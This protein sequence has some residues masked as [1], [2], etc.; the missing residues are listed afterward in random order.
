MSTKIENLKFE[1]EIRK[2]EVA[3]VGEG[4][5]QA[6]CLLQRSPRKP[7]ATDTGRKRIVSSQAKLGMSWVNSCSGIL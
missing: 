4:G 3:Q 1:K 6:C 2:L 5:N 7:L